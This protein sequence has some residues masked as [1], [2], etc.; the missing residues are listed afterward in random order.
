MELNAYELQMLLDYFLIV[1]DLVL[2]CWSETLNSS[3][4]IR[5]VKLTR[6]N[7]D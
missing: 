5:R 3:S 2:V 7:V 6:I 4:L 1:L